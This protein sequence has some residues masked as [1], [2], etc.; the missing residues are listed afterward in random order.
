MGEDIESVIAKL[1]QNANYDVDKA[2][3]G[4]QLFTLVSQCGVSVCKCCCCSHPFLP[5]GGE[6][7]KCMDI[8]IN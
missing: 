5:D 8:P 4:D 3:Q 1:L 2:Q 7:F 6:L